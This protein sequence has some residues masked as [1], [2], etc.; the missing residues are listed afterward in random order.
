MPE[1][2]STQL[3]YTTKR[4]VSDKEGQ[5]LLL[6]D[7]GTASQGVIDREAVTRMSGQHWMSLIN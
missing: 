6:V 1:N 2:G 7:V 3:L 5:G 4:G